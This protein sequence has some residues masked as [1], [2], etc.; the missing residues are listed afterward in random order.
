MRHTN[1]A[2]GGAR[3]PPSVNSVRNGHE[4]HTGSKFWS[5]FGASGTHDGCGESSGESRTVRKK[6]RKEFHRAK[7]VEATYTRRFAK[8]V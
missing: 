7:L 5:G 3:S 1:T 6:W 4:T 2:R 8:R